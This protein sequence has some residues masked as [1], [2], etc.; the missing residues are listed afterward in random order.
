[1]SKDKVPFYKSTKEI[2]KVIAILSFL[3]ILKLIEYDDRDAFETPIKCFS[4][5]KVIFEGKSS[6]EGIHIGSKRFPIF[7]F[8][9][10]HG[11][12]VTIHAGCKLGD[13]I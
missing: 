7:Y 13:D 5:S 2:A 12:K 1:L 4:G 9:D 8:V 3:H 11:N 10:T 6:K